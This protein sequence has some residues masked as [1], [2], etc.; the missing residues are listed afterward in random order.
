ME[1]EPMPRLE[2]LHS[3]RA[4]HAIAHAWDEPVAIACSGGVDSTALLLLATHARNKQSLPHL[5]AV[6]VDHRSRPAT[7]D[8]ARRISALCQRI[9]VPFVAVEIED[10]SPP[11]GTSLEAWWRQQRYEALQR[12]CDDHGLSAAVTAHT[13]DDQ[14]ETILLRLF[15]GMS[16]DFGGMRSRIEF[17]LESGLLPVL[18]PLLDVTREDLEAVLC[19]AGVQPIEDPSNR[20]EELLRNRLRRRIVPQ[21]WAAFPGFEGPLMRAAELSRRDAEVVDQRAMELASELIVAEADAV[22][23]DRG[24]LAELP[25]AIG[26]RLV[27]VAIAHLSDEKDREIGFERIEAVRLAAG[28]RTGSLIELP[29]ELVARV[30]RTRL[31]ISR[32]SRK[33]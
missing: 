2:R 14:V 31:R 23:I 7:K 8:E 25:A 11:S 24:A 21:L 20:N 19:L 16:G 13:R 10:P 1:P 18:R 17:E 29:G 12:A 22:T 32:V 27:R 6:Y 4:Y 26:S 28:G 33:D 5:V 30:E 15:T 9:D 3:T